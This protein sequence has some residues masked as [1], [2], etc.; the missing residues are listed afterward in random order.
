MSGLFP[1]AMVDEL[2]SLGIHLMVTFWPFQVGFLRDL[3]VLR[4]RQTLTEHAVR[5]L[6]G[7]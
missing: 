7:V 1:Q 6:A 4:D 2:Q 3:L 5:A